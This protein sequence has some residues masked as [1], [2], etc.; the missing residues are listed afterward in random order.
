MDGKLDYCDIVN[1]SLPS[2]LT[3]LVQFI[4]LCEGE[5]GPSDKQATMDNLKHLVPIVKG[6]RNPQ[7]KASLDTD[8]GAMISDMK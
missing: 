7:A 6:L 4:P 5:T 8:L 2:Q 1:F 3:V